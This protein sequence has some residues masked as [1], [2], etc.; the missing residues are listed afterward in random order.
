[1]TYKKIGLAGVGFVGDALKHSFERR[2]AEGTEIVAYDKFKR[3]G[4]LESLL[5]CDVVFLCLPTPFI[6]E[7]GY[8]LSAVNEICSFLS[9]NHY[10]GVVVLKSTVEP[11]TTK[12]LAQHFKL[13]MIHNPE[14]LTART[15][16]EDFDS[17]KHIILGATEQDREYNWDLQYFYNSLYPEAKISKSTSDESEMCK[18]FCNCFYASKIQLF[19]EF[20]L[21]A[22]KMHADFETVKKMML[23]NGWINPMHTKV[24]GPDGE[25]SFSN[26]CFPKDVSA[27]TKFM[28]DKGIPN[29]VLSAVISERNKMRK[30]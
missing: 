28:D 23:E 3:L 13:K 22:N 18:L 21:L 7:Y 30:D 27:L 6:S 26:K 5:E 9:K 29:E 24:P 15:A 4:T 17:Q 19:N 8:D 11:G 16:R 12:S 25:L 20:Y 14:F 2:V 1:M 10:Y